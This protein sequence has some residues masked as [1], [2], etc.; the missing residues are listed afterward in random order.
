[1]KIGPN[2]FFL[3]R[4]YEMSEAELAEEIESDPDLMRQ[5]LMSEDEFMA[6]TNAIKLARDLRYRDS[7]IAAGLD[8]TPIPGGLVTMKRSNDK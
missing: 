3:M 5:E 6:K 8:F 7:V 2:M 4:V 1:M